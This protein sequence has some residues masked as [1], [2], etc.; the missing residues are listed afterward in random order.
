[1]EPFRRN[2]DSG[3]ISYDVLSSKKTHYYSVAMLHGVAISCDC[4]NGQIGNR[5]Q[6]CQH[7]RTAE[8]EEARLQAEVKQPER[9]IVSPSLVAEKSLHSAVR[10]FHLLR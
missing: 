4:K 7:K 6:T 10:G 2:N 9:P 1:M 3:L 5:N 8:R